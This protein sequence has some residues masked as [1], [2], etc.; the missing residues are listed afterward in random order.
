M[1]TW[2]PSVANRMAI[3]LPIPDV[4]PVTNATSPSSRLTARI[5]T[6]VSQ[7]GDAP[8]GLGDRR[9]ALVRH[10]L[11][12]RVPLVCGSAARLAPHVAVHGGRRRGRRTGRERIRALRRAVHALRVQ[13]RTA[14]Q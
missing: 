1:T 12:R 2:A 9:R 11:R 4:D 7:W 10:D 6:R 8:G 5:L 13:R 3:A 14:R